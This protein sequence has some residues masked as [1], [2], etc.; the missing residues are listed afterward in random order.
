MSNKEVFFYGGYH[1]RPV[2]QFPPKENNFFKISRKL[3]WDNSLILTGNSWEQ[4][5][6]YSREAFYAAST[7][8][9]CDVFRCMENGRL[10]VPCEH[11]FQQ[12]TGAVC[13]EKDI[14]LDR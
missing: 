13:K 7:D 10:Y 12:Y 3:R 1:F 6:T 5:F 8:K 11:E 9:K 2:G 4:G 14:S